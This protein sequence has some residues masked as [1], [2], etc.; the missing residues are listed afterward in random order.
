MLS[1]SRDCGWS[2]DEIIDLILMKPMDSVTE[3]KLIG[4]Q[5]LSQLNKAVNEAIKA[6]FQ[7]FGNPCKINEFVCQAVVKTVPGNPPAILD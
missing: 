7:P 1:S 2:L 6:G 4:T 5:E 3:Y